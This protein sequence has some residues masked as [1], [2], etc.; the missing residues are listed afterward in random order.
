VHSDFPNALYNYISI[1]G[2]KKLKTLTD[3][4][5]LPTFRDT[6]RCEDININVL[7]IGLVG[8]EWID[9]ASDRDKWRTVVKTVMNFRVK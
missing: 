2:I 7:E 3:L 4:K 6:H 9:L 8:G 5:F 1:H